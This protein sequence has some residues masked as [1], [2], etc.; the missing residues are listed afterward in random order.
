VSGQH[1]N[2]KNLHHSLIYKHD[3]M[4]ICLTDDGS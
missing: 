1:Q 4:L 2:I 3:H